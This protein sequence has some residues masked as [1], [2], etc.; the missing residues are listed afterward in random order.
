MQNT[1][2]KFHFN[3]LQIECYNRNMDCRN[4]FYAQYNKERKCFVK[5]SIITAI[6]NGK[7][8]EDFIEKGVFDERNEN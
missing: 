8:P 7:K 1:Y 3:D 5:K 4:C 6:L 2:H